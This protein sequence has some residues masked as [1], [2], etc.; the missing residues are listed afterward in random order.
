MI[1][2]HNVQEFSHMQKDING[3]KVCLAPI[4]RRKMV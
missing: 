4:Y 1:H 3:I 2:L